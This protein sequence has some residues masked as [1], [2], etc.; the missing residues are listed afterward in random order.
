MTLERDSSRQYLHLAR[1]R[2]VSLRA[3]AQRREDP[4]PTRRSAA[5]SSLLGNDHADDR[6][7]LG[8][9]PD[10]Q[11][12]RAGLEPHAGV[13]LRR[14]TCSPTTEALYR[15]S[16]TPKYTVDSPE[17]NTSSTRNS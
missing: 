7:T 3:A 13:S 1:A 6:S 2:E 9:M 11:V 17:T 14:V 10:H 4:E 5:E 12:S 15:P 16:R 8:R